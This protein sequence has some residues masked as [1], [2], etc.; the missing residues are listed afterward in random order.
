[1]EFVNIPVY[2]L[3]KF[4]NLRF[5]YK[6]HKNTFLHK[7]KWIKYFNRLNFFLQIQ[8]VYLLKMDVSLL[9]HLVRGKMHINS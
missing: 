8:L 5:I 3:K 7:R 1:M 2:F 9:S 4:L 6:L